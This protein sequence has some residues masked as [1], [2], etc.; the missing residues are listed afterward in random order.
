MNA[1]R[2]DFVVFYAGKN[3]TEDLRNYVLDIRY[4]DKIGDESDELEIQLEDSSRLWQ[5]AWTPSKGDKI[6]CSIGYFGQPL[7]NCGTFDVDEITLRGAPDV[8]TIKA[9][10]AG[11]NSPLRTKRSFAHEDKTMAQIAQAVAQA[12]GLTVQ[13]T[14]PNITFKRITQSRETDLAFLN[15]LASDYGCA[16]SVRDNQ[17]IF[18]D[19]FELDRTEPVLEFSRKDVSSYDLRDTAVKTYQKAIVAYREPN[20]DEVVKY[21]AKRDIAYYAPAGN[22]ELEVREKVENQ[23]QAERMGNSKLRKA[24]M[25]GVTGRLSLE[26]NTIALAGNT[27]QM[28][29]DWQRF[30]GKWQISSSSHVLSR[31][32]GYKTDIDIKLIK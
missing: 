15:R 10:A 22:D 26:G 21:D 4:T 32:D 19:F 13:G 7:M 14:I 29:D 1:K 31:S 28:K 5:G 16:F 11:I 17:L 18:T 3:I 2:I 27:I 9:L 8:V 20:T 25:E 6:Q 24:N 30:A 23:Q 12:N